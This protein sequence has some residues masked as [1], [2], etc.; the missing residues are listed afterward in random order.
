MKTLHLLF[1]AFFMSAGLIFSACSDDN[2]DNNG[3]NGNN[4]NGTIADRKHFDIWI[5]LGVT[6]G[7]GQEEALL[8][9]NVSS[10]EGDATIDFVDKGCDVTA[11]L[12]SETII[13][14]DY[15]YQVP[16]AE[17]RF[18]KYRITNEGLV[19]VAEQP[20]KKN[21]YK[22]R[23][24]CHAWTAG[25]TLVII[26][27]NGDANEVIWT[28]L[29]A[30]TMKIT[31]EGNFGLAALTGIEKFSTSGLARYRKSDNTIIYAFQDKN[32]AQS[33]FVA[34]IDATTMTVKSYVEENRAEQMAGT[35]FGE[36]LQDKM[37]FDENENLYIACNSRIPGSKYS[38]QQYGRL[39][40]INRGETKF[41]ADYE[42]YKKDAGKLVTV[43]YLGSNKALL[44]IQDPVH[45]GVPAS[46]GKYEGWGDFYNC[47]YAILDLTTDE[48]TEC[49]YEGEK[50]PY[51]LGTFSQRSCVVNGKAYIGTNPE[52]S[53]PQ[54]YVYDV[55]SG[56]MTKGVSIKD[57]YE[58]SRIVHI[59]K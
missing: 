31:E 20:F 3:N 25:N 1:F 33:F 12:K 5:S 8:V 42:G 36:L 35:A 22:A 10:L 40:R 38:T 59:A 43:E 47:Y 57:G 26:A 15:Y 17:D 45:T 29:D 32:N 30:T 48:V 34:F 37:F 18:S 53:A 16:V 52:K 58:F 51:S 28:K 41:D 49:T 44:Y 6:A 24:Y 9:Q 21:T 23:K 11:T 7:M 39:L 4:G 56:K 46:S 19:T 27:A 2:N 55:K 13:K 54:I 14:G 50:L